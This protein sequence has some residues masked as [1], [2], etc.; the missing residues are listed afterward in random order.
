MILQLMN[1]TLNSYNTSLISTLHGVRSEYNMYCNTLTFSPQLAAP[2]TPNVLRNALA[3]KATVSTPAYWII[4]VLLKL[5]ADLSSTRPPAFAPLVP[6][7]IHILVALLSVV[8]LIVSAHLTACVSMDNVVTSVS[9]TILVLTMPNVEAS[10]IRW[11]ANAFLVLRDTQLS[12][13][14]KS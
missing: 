13:A 10:T 3:T 11:S 4:L 7:E 6:K 8:G 5:S 1:L 12:F 14:K 2:V 9:T